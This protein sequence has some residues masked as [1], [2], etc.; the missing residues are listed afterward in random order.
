MAFFSDI[1][2]K[3]HMVSK[4]HKIKQSIYKNITSESKENLN[5]IVYLNELETK[6]NSSLSVLNIKLLIP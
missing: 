1:F 5:Y 6:I 3:K 4:K 2:Y